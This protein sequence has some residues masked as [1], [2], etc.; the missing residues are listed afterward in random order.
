MARKPKKEKTTKK[1]RKATKPKKADT[2]GKKTR[3]KKAEKVEEIA[4]SQRQAIMNFYGGLI[5]S[6]ENNTKLVS[7]TVKY[8][9]PLSTG[10]LCLDWAFN[11]G[12][13]NG[14]ASVAGPEQ[15]GKSTLCNHLVASCVKN[16]LAFISWIDAEGT[17]NPDLASRI[18]EKYGVELSQ[19][20]DASAGGPTSPWNYYRE[21][22]I[23]KSFSYMHQLIK[24]MPDKVWSTDAKCWVY[25][26]KK[27]NDVHKKMMEVYDVKPV[28]SL[29]TESH[30][31]CPTEYDSVEAG[32]VIDS[33]AAMVTSRDDENEDKSKIRAAEA[34]AFSS[35]IKRVSARLASKGVLLFGTNQL[36]ESPNAGPY[37][38][39]TSYEP[40]GKALQFFTGQRC[41]M[42]SRA[43]GW[44]SGPAS[45]YD[46]ESKRQ[47]EQSVVYEGN[48]LYDY[49]HIKNTKNKPGN[50]N[51]ETFVRVWVADET[52]EGSGFDPAFDV[53]NFLRHTKQIKKSKNKWVFDARPSFGSP[54]I[55]KSLSGIESFT[56][57]E[58][59][60]L[61][62]AETRKDKR[63]MKEALE[64][65]G[66]NKPLKLQEN[67]FAQLKVDND[68]LALKSSKK[69]SKDEDDDGDIEL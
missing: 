17:L 12:I 15:S 54:K 33:F 9:R 41:R 62:L 24:I 21:N 59:K 69:K 47:S 23:E 52:G 13:Y 64:E 5:K 6:V 68:L 39:D 31:G 18:F 67:L 45:K 55:A 32:F 46:K 44:M 8:L 16:D 66:I 3:K 4:V 25:M 58:L 60:K 35:E 43:G 27:R 26:F 61:V 63:L 34:G 1:L 40:G 49:K 50:P 22:V 10:N 42:N 19:L 2:K 65:M 30:Y 56:Y 51:K 28:K 7:N 48:D 14:M 20:E 57:L 29:T 53:F 36:R 37:S 11:G 38:G